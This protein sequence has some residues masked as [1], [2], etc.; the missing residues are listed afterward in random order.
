[1]GTVPEGM[2]QARLV[3]TYKGKQKIVEVDWGLET[4]NNG[5]GIDHYDVYF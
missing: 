5:E 1:M 4:G 2:P 3:I